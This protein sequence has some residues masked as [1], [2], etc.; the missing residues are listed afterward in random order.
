MR[1]VH[2]ISQLSN[3]ELNQKI[4]GLVREERKITVEVLRFLREVEKRMLFAELGYSSLFAYTTGELGYSEAAAS[5]RIEAMRAMREVAELEP[6]IESGELSLSVV[7]QAR[8]AIRNHERETK[9]KITIER[10]RE[11]LLSMPGLSKREAEK[12]LAHELPMAAANGT[13]RVT[14]E[15][16]PEDLAVMDELRR[17][18]GVVQN[19]TELFMSL[20]RAALAKKK[21]ERGEA[22]LMRKPKVTAESGTPPA[23]SKT[24]KAVRKRYFSSQ[25]K[26]AAWL[27]AQGRCEFTAAGGKRCES[28]QGLE[29]D[30]R[31]PVAL[32]GAND[33]R[34]VRLLCRQHNTFEAVRQLGQS[35][36]SLYLP[37]LRN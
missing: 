20:A 32:G 22:E 30:H 12:R 37:G 18:G 2:S 8:V 6:K 3:Q 15:L 36:M 28:R 29:F 4:Q 27:K 23:E 35:T 25:I 21:R 7:A 31:M 19:T 14:L 17:F 13:V 16:T 33:S 5:R 34:N 11:V 26:R 24:C 10:K 9:T 1:L